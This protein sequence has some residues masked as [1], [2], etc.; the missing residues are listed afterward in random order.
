[1]KDKSSDEIFDWIV[2]GSSICYLG[3]EVIIF[4]NHSAWLFSAIMLVII[5]TM[6]EVEVLGDYSFELCTLRIVVPFLNPILFWLENS[7]FLFLWVVCRSFRTSHLLYLDFPLRW[8]FKQNRLVSLFL[9][10]WDCQPGMDCW[11][12]L[13]SNLRF[14]K[15]LMYEEKGM[16]DVID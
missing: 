12:M 3:V 6:W 2:T 16:H 10:N 4:L 5:F 7:F 14:L 1:M 8:S 13:S 11:S 9:A 15:I